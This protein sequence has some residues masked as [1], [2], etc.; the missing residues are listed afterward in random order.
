MQNLFFI[1][2]FF[3]LSCRNSSTKEKNN[4]NLSDTSSI[5]SQRQNEY[6]ILKRKVEDSIAKYNLGSFSDSLIKYIY[7]VSFNKRIEGYNR[8]VAEV[9]IAP[10]NF[11]RKG[12]DTA[13]LFFSYFIKDKIP[14]VIDFEYGEGSPIIG[15]DFSNRKP[16]KIYTVWDG[17]TSYV[18]YD[19]FKMMYEKILYQQSLSRYLKENNT[20]INKTFQRLIS[21]RDSMLQ[22]K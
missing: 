14:V 10:I 17:E 7:V 2:V 6:N 12:G 5:D 11:I 3:C 16:H 20:R 21:S 4:E 22:T 9:S 15:F 13:S 1:L 19:G 18:R 8:T